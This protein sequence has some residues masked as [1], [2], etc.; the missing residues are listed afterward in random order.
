ML[1]QLQSEKGQGGLQSFW[2][3]CTKREAFSYHPECNSTLAHRP[4]VC[5]SIALPSLFD[6]TVVYGL[7]PHSQYKLQ[8]SREL[9][10]LPAVSRVLITMLGT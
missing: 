5:F 1:L 10:W 3:L 7:S 9:V 6:H 2:K 4:T 8:E